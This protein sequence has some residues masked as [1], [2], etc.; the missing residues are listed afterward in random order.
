MLKTILIS[1]VSILVILTIAGFI[2]AKV[3]STVVIEHTFNASVDKV[4]MHWTSV[5]S[6][7]KWWGPT[8]YT[9]PTIKSDFQ[10]GGTYLLSMKAADGTMHFN[11]GTYKEIILNQKIVTAM[12]FADENGKAIPG[13]DVAVPGSWPD[14]VTVTV[15]FRENNG[16]TEVK[17]TE[18]GIPSIMYLFSKLGWKQQFEKFENL[19]K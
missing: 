1:F 12:S 13:R 17:V 8:Y 11:S 16:N 6:I 7:K 4:W 10:V 19:L 3:P 2:A 9:A 15:E 14:E 5:E 18:E